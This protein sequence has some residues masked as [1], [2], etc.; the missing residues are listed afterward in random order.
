MRSARLILGLLAVVLYVQGF[1]QQLSAEVQTRKSRLLYEAYAKTHRLYD[2]AHPL[3]VPQTYSAQWTYAY[4]AEKEQQYF[5]EAP[6]QS[7]RGLYALRF[8][9]LGP[10]A[11]RVSQRLVMIEYLD[12]VTNGR[13]LFVPYI[14]SVIPDRACASYNID[15]L[16][17]HQ[18]TDNFSGIV[19]YSKLTGAL[20]N[21]SRFVNGEYKSQSFLADKK[22]PI[23]KNVNK[24]NA[25]LKGTTLYEYSDTKSAVLNIPK[26]LNGRMVYVG[27]C[28]KT[29]V[30]YDLERCPICCEYITD[31]K[32]HEDHLLLYV[33]PSEVRYSGYIMP[34]RVFDGTLFLGSLPNSFNKQYVSPAELRATKSRQLSL[35][36]LFSDYDGQPMR[37][38][39]D[40]LMSRYRDNIYFL[41]RAAGTMAPKDAPYI[42][43]PIT[44]Y[45][46]IPADVPLGESISAEEMMAK[47]DQGRCLVIDSKSKDRLA[48]KCFRNYEILGDDRIAQCDIYFLKDMFHQTADRDLCDS[49]YISN[50][51]YT[52]D[53][54]IVPRATFDLNDP[55]VVDLDRFIAE[56]DYEEVN[57]LLEPRGRWLEL[58]SRRYV[59]NGCGDDPVYLIDRAEMTDSTVLVRQVFIIKRHPVDDRRT[60]ADPQ[61]GI[62]VDD[63]FLRK[64]SK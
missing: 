39:F 14:R 47:I 49:I 19:C 32:R 36:T 38:L 52:S 10:Y 51:A 3:L 25:I 16:Y 37:P 8:D 26:E 54:Y 21:V 6:I 12:R 59:F 41:K 63:D 43:T 42:V 53:S 29:E 33:S 46:F 22:S 60:K 62:I 31:N 9:S 24:S 64:P 58:V 55:R 23:A 5:C 34:R 18:N 2:D 7:Q 17:N 40:S 35:G 27:D 28:S 4:V 48:V 11:V 44:H 45:S 1:A 56:N 13:P 15:T 57:V 20:I 50:G 30:A 61:A